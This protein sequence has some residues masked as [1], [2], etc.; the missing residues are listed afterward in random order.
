MSSP[1]PYA[2]SV[3]AK[4]THAPV[5]STKSAD[6]RAV[7]KDSRSAGGVELKLVAV[8]TNM[9]KGAKIHPT[10]PSDGNKLPTEFTRSNTGF[11]LHTEALTIKVDQELVKK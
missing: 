4:L 8:I 10:V 11:L 9:G 2:D 6:V 1:H 7:S 5:G 3:K